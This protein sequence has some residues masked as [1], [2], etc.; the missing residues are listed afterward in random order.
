MLPK[1]NICFLGEFREPFWKMY[2]F[3][4]AKFKIISFKFQRTIGKIELKVH[5]QLAA[6]NETK[7]I[8]ARIVQI[9]QK[10]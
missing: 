4:F 8:K 3:I 7:G 5:F 1:S 10:I 6:V 9:I 2:D